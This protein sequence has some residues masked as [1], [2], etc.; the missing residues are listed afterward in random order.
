MPTLPAVASC[1]E[2]LRDEQSQQLMSK[3]EKNSST[4]GL[5]IW[6][7]GK[8]REEGKLFINVYRIL[9]QLEKIAWEGLGA[10][11]GQVQAQKGCQENTLE[12][13]SG[14]RAGTLPW[15]S[16]KFNSADVVKMMVE[17]EEKE[18]SSGHLKHLGS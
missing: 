5:R 7:G 16:P 3:K 11:W 8:G 6:G 4:R 1:G 2:G 13:R 18:K 9:H 14:M 10:E 12:E 17:R 15:L